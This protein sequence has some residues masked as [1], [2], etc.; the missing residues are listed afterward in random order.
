M[1]ARWED[2]V[3]S[4]WEGP[5]GDHDVDKETGTLCD[6]LV[7]QKDYSGMGVGN[8]QQQDNNMDIDS[9]DEDKESTAAEGNAAGGNAARVVRCM[10]GLAFRLKLVRH[11]DIATMKGELRWPKRLLPQQNQQEPHTNVT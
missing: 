7:Q 6:N 1:D 10:S 9:D 3:P 4:I 5:D 11:F 8:D 2:G